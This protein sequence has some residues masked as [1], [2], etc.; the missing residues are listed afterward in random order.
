MDASTELSF[1]VPGSSPCHC[2][3]AGGD[4]IAGQFRILSFN[5]DLSPQYLGTGHCLV[6]GCHREILGCRVKYPKRGRQFE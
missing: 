4:S 1:A 2:R 3:R 6:D 5:A